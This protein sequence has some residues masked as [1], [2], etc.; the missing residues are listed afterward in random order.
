MSELATALPWQDGLA[1][2]ASDGAV[3]ALDASGRRLWE[4]LRAGWG[5]SDLVSACVAEGGLAAHVARRQIE[6]A[7]ASWREIGLLEPPHALG[8]G[9]LEPVHV[10]ARQPAREPALDGVY[11]VGD[12]PVRVRCD[13]AALADLIE[14]ACG[15]FRV[16]D[17][18][19][20]TCVDVVERDGWFGVH[21]ED[22]LLAK[23]PMPTTS[24]A[25]AR[26]RCL[27]ALLEAARFGRRWLGILHASAVAERGGCVLFPGESGAGKST[28]A[29]ALVATG[30]RFVT[31]DYAPLEAGAWRIWPVPYAPSVKR[32]SWG[33]LGRYHPA[34]Q[35][36]P[37][38]KHRG[39]QL[40]YL[41]L[42]G[43][44]RMPLDEG[45]P[46]RALVFLRREDAGEPELRPIDAN[47]A[48]TRLCH[49]ASMLDRRPEMLAETLH[50]IQSIPTYELSYRELEPALGPVRSLL[51]ES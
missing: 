48:L 16:D 5:V 25:G 47:Q 36:A 9:M 22:V 45:L 4:A 19:A 37:S 26:H 15:P 12:R 41:E 29:A 1:I 34:L 10:L 49:A 8:P 38:H 14:A 50:W 23:A 13:D 51:R 17:G 44:C 27:T 33:L 32:G 21:A 24:L 39:L 43:C 7:L 20:A 11:L 18:A 35:R 28:I 2:V 31:D 30:A 42:D 46:V 3:Y 40:R 6:R